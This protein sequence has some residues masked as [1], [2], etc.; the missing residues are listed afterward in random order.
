MADGFVVRPE[1]LAAPAASFDAPPPRSP[2]PSPGPAPT[3]RPSATW[4][5]T[6]SR[7]GRSRP[8]TCPSRPR[9]SRGSGA[10]PTP[11][12]RSG[13]D[14][15]RRP[16]STPP[17][18]TARRT[19]S[20][21]GS[22]DGRRGLGSSR[23]RRPLVARRGRAAPPRRRRVWDRL[24]GA[25]TPRPPPATTRRRR[26]RAR[27]PAKPRPRR[28]RRGADRRRRSRPRRRTPAGSPARYGTTQTPSRRRSV[29][30]RSSSPAAG[31]TIVVG[32]LAAV[33]TFGVAEAA[34]AGVTAAL[35]SAA[36]A[37]G[38][39]LSGTVAA[40]TGRRPDGGDVRR[41][42]E[43]SA[44]TWPPRG[45]AWGCSIGATSRS[46]RSG[47]PRRRGRV[48]RR[49]GRRPRRPRRRSGRSH[50]GGRP[51]RP[52]RSR[53][54][55]PRRVGPAELGRA[56]R[57]LHARG[58]R[59]PGRPSLPAPRG[60]DGRTTRVR[61]EERL[62]PG[63][64]EC[65]TASRTRTPS[66]A[67]GRTTP[68]PTPSSSSH[69]DRRTRRSRTRSDGGQT[70]RP[71]RR[72]RAGAR[73]SRERPV[74]GSGG[75]G[76]AAGS[77]SSPGARQRVTE[78]DP[79]RARRRVE[80]PPPLRDDVS[81]W[82][83]IFFDVAEPLNAAAQTLA[84]ALRLTLDRGSQASTRGESPTRPGWPSPSSARSS[85]TTMPRPVPRRPATCPSSTTCPRS[86]S[87]VSRRATI[88]LQPRSRRQSPPH[89][90]HPRLALRADR[91]FATLRRDLQ[92]RSTGIASSRDTLSD[93][94]H[95]D[96]W[97]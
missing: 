66:S 79:Y 84:G 55:H 18:T 97:R 31:A 44:A 10:R 34:A 23:H 53:C 37:V 92:T 33:A 46:P 68:G 8:A 4:P 22:D 56:G 20:A 89:V 61:G 91:G 87:C 29:R 51:L 11:S 12:G 45:S 21:E 76:P 90:R 94:T 16:S 5:G 88:H 59:A 36:A 30:S 48:G 74:A 50:R 19:V 49:G 1:L 3:S 28:P 62:R 71:V 77:R 95:A 78:Q 47:S 72:G 15:V 54:S 80:H 52:A 39:E 64:G 67:P 40:I 82:E 24:A 38:V 86:S 32:R 58:P 69:R 13:V 41:D 93:A 60:A 14:S 2:P 96:R 35:V 17:A 57:P 81:D 85:S 26:R 42:R 6:T 63:R 70:A 25:S 65:P 73:R 43:R 27:G 75:E 7:A 9:G 83:E